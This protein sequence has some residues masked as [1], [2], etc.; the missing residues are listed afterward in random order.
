MYLLDT[1]IC[2]RFLNGRSASI[3]KKLL[4]LQANQIVT[5]SVVKAELFYG[6]AKSNQPT[7]TKI[8]QEKRLA[9]WK[10]FYFD[11]E[12]AL[13]YANIRS[14][15]EKVGTPI[16]PNDLMIASIALAHQFILVTVN[17]REFSRI[18]DLQLE[19]WD[20]PVIG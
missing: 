11:D 18:K 17:T 7:R 12:A 1:N 15:L 9:P 19:N 2:I 3:T 13:V 20:N 6:A 10:S 5:C 14:S 8:L 16:G 4:S